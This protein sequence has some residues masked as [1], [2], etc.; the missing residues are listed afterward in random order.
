[1]YNGLNYIIGFHLKQ[2][3]PKCLIIEVDDD[4]DLI[5]WDV[6]TDIPGLG[7]LHAP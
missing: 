6:P 2:K 1:V 5:T 4:V 3:R 7:V